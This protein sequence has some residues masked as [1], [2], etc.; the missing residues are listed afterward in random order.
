MADLTLLEKLR[1]LEACKKPGDP[2]PPFLV[3]STNDWLDP[4]SQVAKEAADALEHK[5]RLQ[6]LYDDLMAG[7]DRLRADTDAAIRARLKDCCA[8]LGDDGRINL[9]P[10]VTVTERCAAIADAVAAKHEAIA[11]DLFKR[12][13]EFR[14]R[15]ARDAAYDIAEAIRELPEPS[16]KHAR[17][18]P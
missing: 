16:S 2:M 1:Q 8:E 15:A 3:E 11:R 10:D 14:A 18:K 5:D 4:I 9:I 17:S 12:P 13:G 6:T 7:Y